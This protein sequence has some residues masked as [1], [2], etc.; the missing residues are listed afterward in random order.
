MSSTE[1]FEQMAEDLL[2]QATRSRNPAERSQLISEAVRWHMMA[3][4]GGERAATTE[5]S[6]PD[7]D[8]D[9][10]SGGRLSDVGAAPGGSAAQQG[11]G[12]R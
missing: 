3:H 10:Q 8:Q 2:R 1:H 6:W 7:P 11:G 9:H 4:G 5:L 12:Q